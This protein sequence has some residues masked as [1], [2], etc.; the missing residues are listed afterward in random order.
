MGN[1]DLCDMC[2]SAIVNGKCSCG[3]WTEPEDASDAQKAFKRVLEDFHDMKRFVFTGDMP[4]LGVA[5]VFFRGDYNDCKKIEKFIH[6]MKNRPY[7][8]E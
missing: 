2:G 1:K 3:T 6:L 7:Y 5:V 8:E 4:H